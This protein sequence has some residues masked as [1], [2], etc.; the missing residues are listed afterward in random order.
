VLISVVASSPVWRS[1][2]ALVFIDEVALYRGRLLLRWVTVWR[3][4]NHI[5]IACV[6]NHLVQ[7]SLMSVT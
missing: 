2:N 1:D 7:L 3:Q 6:I 5:G 4:V